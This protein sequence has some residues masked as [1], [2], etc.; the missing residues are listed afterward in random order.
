MSKTKLP[1][2][3]ISR[4]THNVDLV[5]PHPVSL[6]RCPPQVLVNSQGV[7]MYGCLQFE[8]RH[9]GLRQIKVAHDTPRKPDHLLLQMESK[10]FIDSIIRF[11]SSSSA[12]TR[13]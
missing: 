3:K 2:S 1:T 8:F 6:V 10:S 7:N 12:K 11:I 4:I 5:W 9:F 13:S